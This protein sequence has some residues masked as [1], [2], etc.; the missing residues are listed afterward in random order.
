MI[1]IKRETEAGVLVVS[2]LQDS[3]S[4]LMVGTSES[5]VPS[6]PLGVSQVGLLPLAMCAETTLRVRRKPLWMLQRRI[7]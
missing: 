2:L 1:L 6:S 4:F 7:L 5:V 3:R